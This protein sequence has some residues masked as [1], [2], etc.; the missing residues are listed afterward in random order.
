MKTSVQSKASTEE[1]AMRRVA[2]DQPNTL[3]P[4]DTQHARSLRLLWRIYTLAFAAA[5]R[6]ELAHQSMPQ[7]SSCPQ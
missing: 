3:T 6:Q 7:D 5:E 1:E 4:R 2:R